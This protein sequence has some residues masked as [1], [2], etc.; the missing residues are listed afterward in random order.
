MKRILSADKE[1]GLT[2]IFHYDDATD[3]ITIETRQDVQ[4]HVD[5]ATQLRND[6]DYT[7]QNM[8]EGWLHYAHIPA[9]IVLK[10]R[11]EH[12]LSIYKKEH[13]KAVFRK[14]NELY[15]KLKTTEMMH[16]PKG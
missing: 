4:A 1:T 7:R 3:N 5:A 10:L 9:S 15:P 6:S 16:N 12:G 13:L 8:K 11:F 2:E 14:I